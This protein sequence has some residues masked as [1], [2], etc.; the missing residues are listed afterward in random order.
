[1]SITLNVSGKIFKVSRDVICKS[2]LFDGMLSDCIVDNEIIIDRSAN[3][4]KHVYAYLLDDKYP[5]PRK[6]YSELDYYLVPHDIDSLYVRDNFLMDKINQIDADM[7]KIKNNLLMMYDKVFELETDGLDEYRMAD[8]KYP[9]CWVQC[10]ERNL[11]CSNH[12]GKCCN[13][14]RDDADN[15]VFCKNDVECHRIYCEEHMFEY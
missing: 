8:C 7:S 10:P 9:G 4:F 1:M 11:T 5:Y 2:Q 15:R 12:K 13:F 6:Y 3:L 14:L